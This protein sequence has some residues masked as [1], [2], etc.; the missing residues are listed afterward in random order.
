MRSSPGRVGVAH[1]GEGVVFVADEQQVPPRCSGC[2]VIFGN[3]REDGALK[4]QLQHH[5]QRAREPRI[6]ADR[7][8]QGRSPGRIRGVAPAAAAVRGSPGCGR[9]VYA[10]LGGQNVRCTTGLSSNNDRNTTMP[11]LMEERRRGSSVLQPCVYQRSTASSW[12]RRAGPARRAV[13][14]ANDARDLVLVQER[15]Q[16]AS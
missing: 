14:R 8:V 12:W 11:S 9:P 5:T 6:Q 4:V 7:K 13:G 16:S 2:A 10:L 15:L 1:R 3:A